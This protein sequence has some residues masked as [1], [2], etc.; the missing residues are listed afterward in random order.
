MSL[1]KIFFFLNILLIKTHIQQKNLFLKVL[2]NEN[3]ETSVR[4]FEK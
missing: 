2:S 1:I 3:E 4:R